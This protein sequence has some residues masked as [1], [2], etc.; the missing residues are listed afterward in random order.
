M[1]NTLKLNITINSEIGFNI[2]NETIISKLIFSEY[3]YIF[4]YDEIINDLK[5][6]FKINK[7]FR[8]LTIDFLI[9]GELENSYRV[10]NEYSEL[11][12]CKINFDRFDDFQVINKKE[13]NLQV[14]NIT[15][16]ANKRFIE[17]IKTNV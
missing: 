10:I 8:M 2:Q 4:D 12:G 1:D 11:K 3:N 5:T 15:E 16:F 14:K 13:I 9:N 6:A 17:L 7:K